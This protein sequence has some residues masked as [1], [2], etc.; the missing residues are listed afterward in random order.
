MQCRICFKL[1]LQ[2]TKD[3]LT[4]K[5]HPHFSLQLFGENIRKEVTKNIQIKEATSCKIIYFIPW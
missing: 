3:V 1:M 4:T 2:A 5:E